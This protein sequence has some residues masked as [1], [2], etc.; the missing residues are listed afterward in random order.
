MTEA[1]H[2]MASNPLPPAIRKPGSVG[3]AAGPEITILDPN[4]PR[5]LPHG[6]T[7][8]IAIRGPNVTAGYVANPEANR[9]AFSEG[10]FRTGDQGHFDGDGYLFISGRLKELI[11]RGG[12]KISPREI[13]EAL[14]SLPGVQQAVAFAVPHRTLGEDVAAAVVLAKG[15]SLREEQARDMLRERIAPFKVPARI[16]FVDA[17]PKGPTGKLQRI[18]LADKLADQLN[19]RYVPP[20]NEVEQRLV[21]IWQE[22]LEAPNVGIESN[23]FAL[24]GDSL[25]AVRIASRAAELGLAVPIDALFREPTI[26]RLAALV[27]P[28]ESFA[29]EGEHDHGTLRL[30]GFQRFVLHP[31]MTTPERFSA[32]SEAVFDL[33]AAVDRAALERALVALA[34]RHD[35]LSLRF[36]REGS[37]WQMQYLPLPEGW[38]ALAV[39][40]PVDGAR[41]TEA[42]TAAHGRFELDRPP[43]FKVVYSTGAPGRIAIIAHHLVADAM[44]MQIVAEEFA[45]AYQQVLAGEAIALPAVPTPLMSF[46]RRYDAAARAG[47][48]HADAADWVALADR[49]GEPGL[50]VSRPDWPGVA[51]LS[52]VRHVAIDFG[53]HSQRVLD[54]A[55]A[56][57][58]APRDVVLAASAAALRE[59]SGR[60]RLSILLM[61]SGREQPLLGDLSRTVGCLANFVPLVLEL[62]EARAL[63]AI[64]PVVQSALARLPNS[65]LSL[66]AALSSEQS[67]TRQRV[68]KLL[69][70]GQLI[71]NYKGELG[72]R[73]PLGPSSAVLRS[74][75]CTFPI[76]NMITHL[77]DPAALMVTCL[78]LQLHFELVGGKLVGDLY[79]SSE[80]YEESWV[81]RLVAGLLRSLEAAKLS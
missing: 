73:T 81:Q 6:S 56:Q 20:R 28:I 26:A 18:G 70:D 69:F 78:A 72:P 37:H 23:F 22:V 55:R 11:N 17:I 66:H 1:S 16:V 36:V 45:T 52:S 60:D 38:L 42:V 27:R 43:L 50:L 34:E 58:A 2:Q 47:R 8:E 57:D 59:L 77:Q 14:L 62:G 32:L 63:E 74:A 80:L 65:G 33:P 5:V 9:S 12:E 31:L 75:P 46:Y 35:A 19:D 25:R 61:S 39:Q 54:H 71:I 76:E 53:E 7:G 64:R 41:F 44:S 67:A 10:W 21:E 4:E 49:A 13:D 79:Y 48:F 40:P 3:V 51:V 24:G 29:T 30:Y 15:A 68:G